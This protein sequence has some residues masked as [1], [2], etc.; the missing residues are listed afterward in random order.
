MSHALAPF[1]AAW[2]WSISNAYPPVLWTIFFGTIA[3]A[4]GFW[5]AA[6]WGRGP[7]RPAAGE[8]RHRLR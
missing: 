4:A 8:P 3:A 5:L 6:S 7:F 1:G 2:I